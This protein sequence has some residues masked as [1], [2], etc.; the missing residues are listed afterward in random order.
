MMKTD[1]ILSL[2]PTEPRSG[3]IKSCSSDIQFEESMELFYPH[4]LSNIDPDLSETEYMARVRA[5]M[6]QVFMKDFEFVNMKTH[7]QRL[8]NLPIEF[9]EISK[10]GCFSEDGTEKCS[11]Y[12]EKLGQLGFNIEKLETYQNKIMEILNN[13]Q[14]KVQLKQSFMQNLKADMNTEYSN[15]SEIKEE[16]LVKSQ[17]MPYFRLAEKFSKDWPFW[18]TILSKVSPNMD[19][20]EFM[21]V[22]VVGIN[23]ILRVSHRKVWMVS[24]RKVCQEQQFQGNSVIREVQKICNGMNLYE[25]VKFMKRERLLN[26]LDSA[27]RKK[28]TS[29]EISSVI[30]SLFERMAKNSS[31][32]VHEI[33]EVSECLLCGETEA[34]EPMVSLCVETTVVHRKCLNQWTAKKRNE[35]DCPFC[36]IPL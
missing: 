30:R 22:L 17:I 20:D 32:H 9:D 8:L 31:L 18:F 35:P 29:N 7:R 19:T 36:R 26:A 3:I 5:Q 24:I 25:V 27:A 2:S 1:S 14:L 10:L 23:D 16:Q 4:L 28:W 13:S 12:V 11:A 15:I 33:D 6:E 21:E 34:N